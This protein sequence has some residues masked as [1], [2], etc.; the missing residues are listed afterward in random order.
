[1]VLFKIA[2]SIY[3]DYFEIR[4]IN[5]HTQVYVKILIMIYTI[6]TIDFRNR[7]NKC[8]KMSSPSW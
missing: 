5:V 6:K 4:N 7:H 1:M 8:L 3:D 2:F